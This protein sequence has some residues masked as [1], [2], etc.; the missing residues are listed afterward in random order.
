MLVCPAIQ[1]VRQFI[2]LTRDRNRTAE[3]VQLPLRKSAFAYSNRMRGVG[4]RAYPEFD[5]AVSQVKFVSVT[6]SKTTQTLL[7][8]SQTCELKNPSS[9]NRQVLPRTKPSNV[10]PLPACPRQLQSKRKIHQIGV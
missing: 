5:A 10:S 6:T 2:G 7:R 4:D 1:I 8:G 3:C 9:G